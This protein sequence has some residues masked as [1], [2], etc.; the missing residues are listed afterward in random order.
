MRHMGGGGVDTVQGHYEHRGTCV[1]QGSHD[2]RG[3]IHNSGFPLGTG[4]MCIS[5][6]ICFKG[7]NETQGRI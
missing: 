2:T 5:W 4:R 3:H 6:S 1:V 7:S